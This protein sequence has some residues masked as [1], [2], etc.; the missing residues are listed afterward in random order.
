M[1]LG[2]YQVD[3]ANSTATSHEEK[4]L[5]PCLLTP[6]APPLKQTAINIK[7]IKQT[8]N[9][10]HYAFAKARPSSALHLQSPFIPC[11]CISPSLFSVGDTTHWPA[12]IDVFPLRI[13]TQTLQSENETLEELELKKYISK[14]LQSNKK[15][16]AQI[17][18]G[19][20]PAE[21]NSMVIWGRRVQA[22]AMTQMAMS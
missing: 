21:K 14:N 18:L 6:L 9:V 11:V 7:T 16:S 4:K 12:R 17:N 22:G 10:C 20:V 3:K 15:N 13:S 5:L 2:L 8:G 1:H 19:C